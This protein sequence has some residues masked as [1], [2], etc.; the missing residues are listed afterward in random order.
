[1][2]IKAR[3]AKRYLLSAPWFSVVLPSSSVLKTLLRSHLH[4]PC[5]AR[6]KVNRSDRTPTQLKRLSLHP[7]QAP[8]DRY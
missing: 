2:R 6:P 4:S 7:S 1:V 5:D 3:R 8:L